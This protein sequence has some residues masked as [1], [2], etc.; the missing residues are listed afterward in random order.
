MTGI[1]AAWTALQAQVDPHDPRLLNPPATEHALDALAATL[2]ESQLPFPDELRASLR[3]HDGARAPF[4]R[5]DTA[6][7]PMSAGEI[8]EDLLTFREIGPDLEA[9][10]PDAPVPPELAPT[11]WCSRWLPVATTGG[12][13]YLC[14]DFG[15][16]AAGRVGQV[17]RYFRSSVVGRG[18]EAASYE[19]WLADLAACRWS[20]DPQRRTFLG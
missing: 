10:P 3:R 1:D 17:I 9:E 5:G 8:R 18:V 11:W 4:F 16:G 6:W 12:M 13:D 14:I 2:A 20:W 15:P 7:R 19:A